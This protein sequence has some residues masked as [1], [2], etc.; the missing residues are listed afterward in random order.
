MT[1]FKLHIQTA[2]AQF[3]REFDS[4]KSMQ[5]YI[6]RNQSDAIKTTKYILHNDQW[7]RFATFGNQIIPKSQLQTILQSLE[8]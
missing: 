7:E 8:E 2:S 5:Q 4:I 6:R 1:K 3:D